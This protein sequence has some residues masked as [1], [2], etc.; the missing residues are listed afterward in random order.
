MNKRTIIF[1]CII[2]L[3]LALICFYFGFNVQNSHE[4]DLNGISFM[5]M[6]ISTNS[7]N[8]WLILKNMTKTVTENG[9]IISTIGESGIYANKPST[10]SD[11][12]STFQWSTPFIVE[13]DILGW[14][15]TPYIQIKDKEHDA[16]QSFSEISIKNGSHVKIVSNKTAVSYIIDNNTMFTKKTNFNDAQ[17]GF[18]LINGTVEYKNFKIFCY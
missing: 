1:L 5:D 17:I 4:S 10:S 16:S 9:T 11:W 12:N 15:G 7:S 8:D 3:C 2:I 6:G 14:N 18:R 13:F